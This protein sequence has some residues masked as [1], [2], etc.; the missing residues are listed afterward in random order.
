M[1]IKTGD[2]YHRALHLSEIVVKRG[3]FKKGQIIAR[4]G[5]SANGSENGVGAH[6]HWSYW[7]HPG[8]TPRPGVTAT[9]DFE[10]AVRAPDPTPTVL[11]AMGGVRDEEDDMFTDA[12]RK[13]LIQVRDGIRNT[14]AGIWHG[15]NLPTTKGTMHFDSGVISIVA[16]NRDLIAKQAGEIEA[17][18]AIVEQLTARQNV[19]IDEARVDAARDRGVR[20]ANTGLLGGPTRR[21]LPPGVQVPM[22][23]SMDDS[24][25]DP[26]V[27]VP[28]AV[29][30]A[31]VNP[32]DQGE[33]DPP[34]VQPANPSP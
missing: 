29:D 30:P 27:I 22:E 26:N 5:A 23:G 15:G 12:D 2:D 11:G 4:S 24:P 19:A 31:S 21:M 1:M 10:V 14:H 9:Q 16:D 17:L 34:V 25:I 3:S 13:L 8:S 32:V 6:L 33:V 28:D 18:K 20:E 7:R